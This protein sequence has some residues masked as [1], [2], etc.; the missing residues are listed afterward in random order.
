MINSNMPD[1]L[2]FA[3]NSCRG[4]I[5]APYPFFKNTGRESREGKIFPRFRFEFKMTE[6]SEREKRVSCNSN[7]NIYA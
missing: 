4:R 3:C 1:I 2:R 7:M 5:K 6:A